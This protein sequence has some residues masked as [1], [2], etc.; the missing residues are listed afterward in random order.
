MSE[1]T[2]KAERVAP[3]GVSMLVLLVVVAVLAVGIIALGLDA[4]VP[5]MIN[6]GILVLYGL[7]YLKIKWSDLAEG[8]SESVK[9]AV[10]VMVIILLIGAV[11]GTWIAS[12]TV[13][14]IIFYGLKVFS[15]KFFLV[16]VVLI[17]SVMSVVTGSS[18][19]TMGTIGVAFMGVAV[20]LGINPAIAAG[21]IACGAFFGDKQSPMSDSTIFAA[22]VAKTDLYAHVKSMLFT[23]GPSIL[24]SCVIFTIIGLSAS[25][26]GDMSAVNQ[27]TEGLQGAYNF[28][29]ALLIPLI[30][31]IVMIIK[32]VPAIPT[33]FISACVG[34]LF[35]AIFQGADLSAVLSNFFSGN[36]GN[37]GDPVIDKLLTRGGMS[38]MFYTD[39][40]MIVS[41]SM[42]GLLQRCGVIAALMS[43]IAKLCAKR[44]SLIV[45]HLIS[46][47]VLSYLAA[48]PYMAMLLPANALGEKYD[49]LG[50]DR[51]VLSRTC[52]DGG[53][54]VCPMVPW[55]SSGVYTAATLGVA[56][57][58]YMPYY[59]MG[60]INPIFVIICAVTGFG[61]KKADPER[62]AELKAERDALMHKG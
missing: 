3:F 47:Y 57:M 17:C 58:S 54:L 27:I 4:Q 32:K 41:L 59:L 61:I 35:T 6:I 49:E 42:A 50:I 45:T 1:K 60:F 20:G 23:T 51:S 52:E 7:L 11:V 43:K 30:I 55:G 31:M 12:G 2:K 39:I 26:S 36:V 15:P 13:P 25:G 28:T 24:V 44:T 34:M 10:E 14:L 40:L 53:T 29:P 48:D 62:L 46:G 19:T 16:S 33:M 22:A 5:I 37:T 8:I 9:S 56:T 18:W 21:A 38:S